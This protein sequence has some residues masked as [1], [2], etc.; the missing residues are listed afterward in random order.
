MR[1]ALTCRDSPPFSN[2]RR[3][4]MGRR[5]TFLSFALV[6]AFAVGLPVSPAAAM[7]RPSGDE[8]MLAIGRE[9]PGFGGLFR[10]RTGRHVAWL[11]DPS[12]AGADTLRAAL[13]DVLILRG[14]F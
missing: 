1:T 8:Q 14:D 7:P 12:S 4:P 13:G 11:Q 5:L 9:V 3:C 2:R 6:V 10:D